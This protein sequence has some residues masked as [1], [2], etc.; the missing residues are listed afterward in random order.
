MRKF[1]HLI[2]GVFFFTS[3]AN[4]NYW[5]LPKQSIDVYTKKQGILVYN[6][7]TVRVKKTFSILNE[8]KK[9]LNVSRS[10]DPLNIRF[11]DDEG[12]TKDYVLLPKLLAPDYE[13]PPKDKSYAYPSYIVKSTKK[14]TLALKRKAFEVPE[15]GSVYLNVSVPEVN[16]FQFTPKG[17]T[18]K[19]NTG[20][21]GISLGVDYYHSQKQ[22]FNLSV[23]TAM[24]FFLPFPVP[25]DYDT[26]QDYEVL[27][28][29]Y[30]SLSNNHRV[31]RFTFGYGLVFSQNGYSID[32]GD[33]SLNIEVPKKD[34]EYIKHIAFGNTFSAYYQLRKSLHIGVIYRPTYYRPNLTQKFGY[35]HLI[36]VD[37]MWKI[38]LK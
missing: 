27:S 10:K 13:D 37:F 1:V 38:K 7:D 18:T 9:T 11:I 20:F 15:K 30:I 23:Y 32:Y 34:S 6:Q 19:T 35:E 4:Q 8:Y 3:C 22:F 28:S 16:S 33:N 29:S 2:L 26:E 21:L 36:S 24:D 12:L 25:F 14:D 31:K 5:F 17:E